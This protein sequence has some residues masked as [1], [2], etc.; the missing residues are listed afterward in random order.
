MHRSYFAC[1]WEPTGC[2]NFSRN[3]AVFRRNR[4]VPEQTSPLGS[5]E[6]RRARAID[7]WSP[8]DQRA[9]ELQ[10]AGMN[11]CLCVLSLFLQATVNSKSRRALCVQSPVGDQWC[12]H[13]YVQGQHIVGVLRL[14]PLENIAP[15]TRCTVCVH[16]TAAPNRTGRRRPTPAIPFG[17]IERP[18]L[19][20]S[21]TDRFTSPWPS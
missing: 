21:P 9:F 10:N 8:R 17:T 11:F 3:I 12:I 20:R 6:V 19:G 7:C 15:E 16:G 2:P 5:I 13:L 14:L 4:P 1:R 18:Q